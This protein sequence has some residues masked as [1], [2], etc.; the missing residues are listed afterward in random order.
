MPLGKCAR[1][2]KVLD[3]KGPPLLRLAYCP[4]CKDPLRQTTYRTGQPIAEGKPLVGNRHPA[5][6]WG[7][8]AERRM[9]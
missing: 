9:K 3:W 1:C 4:V 5:T 7:I 2:M 6:L 8:R